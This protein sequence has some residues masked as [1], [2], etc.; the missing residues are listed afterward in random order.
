MNEQLLDLAYDLWWTTQPDVLALWKDLDPDRWEEI[1]HN[2]VALLADADLRNAAP[3]WAERAE[4]ILARWRAYHAQPPEIDAPNVAYLCMEFGLHECLPIYAGG[5][6]MLAGDHL[7]SA[8]DIGLPLVA[9]GLFYHQGYFKQLLHDGQQLAAYTPN[10]PDRLP[11]RPVFDSGG[12]RLT[13]YIPHGHHYY[14]ARVWEVRVGRVRLFLLDTDFDGNAV[15][16]RILTR[17]LYGGTTEMRV[18]QEVL[19]GIGGVRVLSALG[20]KPDVYHMNEG[21]AAFAVLELWA[22]GLDAGL[23]RDEA[24]QRARAQCVFTT[25]TPEGAGHD[26]FDYELIK[27]ALRGYRESLGLP[28][29]AFMDRGRVRPGDIHEPLCMTVL[30]LRGSRGANGVSALHGEVSRQ[31]W[32]EMRTEI[33]SITN[34]VH[35]TAWLAPETITLFD[36]HLPGWHDRLE[37]VDF[38]AS[39]EQ[40]PTEAL[41]ATR[42]ARRQ[43]LIREVRRLV[44]RAIMDDGALTVGFAR[45]F[46]PY[47]RANLLFTDPDRLARLLEQGVQILY[48]GKAHPNDLHG[49]ELLAEVVRWSRNPRFRRSV[50]FLPDYDNFLGRLMTQGCDVWL[51]NPRRPREA[52]G[53]SGQKAAL[54]GNLNCSILD[55]WWP[56]ICDGKNGWAIG[57]GKTWDHVEDQDRA[58]A[59]ALYDVLEKQVLPTFRDD[60]AWASMM[61]HAIATCFPVFN[62]NRMVRE[63]VETLYRRKK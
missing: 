49:Q 29:G 62:T 26:K 31:M 16:H 48:A 51:N 24:W 39:A 32:R 7:R 25:H 17:Q 23:K 18:A 58:D 12:R 46:A 13:V 15:E 63:Y 50:H 1:G 57:Q 34:G 54:N 59:L 37:D 44:G 45:R 6:G 53:T 56:E 42:D 14:A 38:W 52:S 28:E 5:L 20:I 41:L 60:E 11:M 3:G 10:D 4:A 9:V 27:R 19:L 2:P 36:T 21:H 43:R 8:S 22:R 33:G 47:K 30:A 40:L 61:K 35:P 55:G